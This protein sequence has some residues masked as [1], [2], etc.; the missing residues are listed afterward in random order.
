MIQLKEQSRSVPEHK[1][2][3]PYKMPQDTPLSLYLPFQKGL[4]L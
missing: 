1:H 3:V 2:L 4:T